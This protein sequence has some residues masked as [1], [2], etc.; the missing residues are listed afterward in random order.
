MKHLKQEFDKLSFKEV[1]VYSLSVVVTLAG[2]TLLFMSLLIDPR[3]E[4]HPSVL[5]AFGTIC[6]FSGSLLGISM[7]YS[8]EL[9]GFKAQILKMMQEMSVQPDI[10]T[11]ET[12]KDIQ[13]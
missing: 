1:L 7:H 8:T 10:S 12:T 4:I 2:L 3:G 5:A 13:Q 6:V 9:A 11:S